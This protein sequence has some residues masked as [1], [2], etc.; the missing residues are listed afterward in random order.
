MTTPGL[1]EKNIDGYL[2]KHLASYCYFILT[3]TLKYPKTGAW[4]TKLYAETNATQVLIIGWVV[5][6]AINIYCLVAAF[7]VERLLLEVGLIAG[8]TGAA[9]VRN[10]IAATRDASLENLWV[11]LQDRAF[12]EQAENAAGE[13]K[14]S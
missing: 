9:A 10:S 3:R 6:A 8:I 14:R 1:R 4:L 12:A 7:S 13:V 5:S 2:C 11:L